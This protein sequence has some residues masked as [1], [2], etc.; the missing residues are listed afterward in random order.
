M[1]IVLPC[2]RVNN[3]RSDHDQSILN[4]K[5][6]SFIIDQ[7]STSSGFTASS[8]SGDLGDVSSGISVG[9]EDCDG[10]NGSIVN[11]DQCNYHDPAAVQ[12]SDL[13]LGYN[14]TGPVLSGVQMQVPS[15][16]IYGLLG[17]SGC[18]KTSLIKCIVGYFRPARGSVFIYGYPPGHLELQIPGPNIGYMPQECIL[19]GELTIGETLTYFARLFHMENKFIK[20]NIDHMISI[21]GLPEASRRISTLSGGQM[22]RVSFVAAVLHKP[23][24]II[25][26]EPTAGVDPIVT[27]AIWKYLQQISKDYKIAVVLTTHYIEEARK[28]GCVGLMREGRILEEDHPQRLMARYKS[29]TLEQAF[30]HICSRK[31]PVHRVDHRSH[32]QPT[33]SLTLT[34]TSSTSTT[35]PRINGKLA[36]TKP[37]LSG[38]SGTSSSGA[39]SSIGQASGQHKK[40]DS[41]YKPSPAQ[42]PIDLAQLFTV[43]LRLWFHVVF[44]IFWKNS[45]RNIRSPQF[46]AL[47]F[48]VPIL[49]VVLS[50][51]VLG[52]DPFD[53]RVAVIDEDHT[54][55]SRKFV[56]LIDPYF[57]NAVPYN[58]LDTALADIKSLQTWGVI[59]IKRNFSRGFLHRVDLNNNRYNTSLL[60]SSVIKLHGDLTNDLITIYVRR[61]LDRTFYTFIQNILE[62]RGL[63]PTLASLPIKLED[64]IYGAE[65]RGRHDNFK[66]FAI[67]GSMAVVCFSIGF[68]ITAI[69]ITLER[70]DKMLDRH[71]VIGITPLQ[72]L[73]AHLLNRQLANAIQITVILVTCIHFL[74]VLDVPSIVELITAFIVLLVVSITGM[75]LGMVFATITSKFETVAATSAAALFTVLISSGVL[76]PLEAMKPWLRNI[77]IYSPVTQGSRSLQYILLRGMD[78]WH[79][80]VY[81]GIINNF[82]WAI[83]F[84]FIGMRQFKF[85]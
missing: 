35:A 78:L 52:L 69:V 20:Q 65:S 5:Q 82:C 42:S 8:T 13:Y 60:S 9:S 28:A 33:S 43:D 19:Y 84:F 81:A 55:L 3:Y 14:N 1:S 68:T 15:A 21:L 16:S 22:R 74:G 27:E 30:L 50:C 59:H 32:Q 62:G 48:V 34:S 72:F 11:D 54:K 25:L 76:W 7:P 56:T 18:G 2:S 39:S 53:T 73:T 71:Y 85:A 67:P 40:I 44:T 83:L 45:I 61:S 46:M 80:P 51:I 23:K 4:F 10:S 79:R 49:P 17:P 6:S 26:D 37:N 36:V 24:L 63:R 29:V 70:N 77:A 64:P 75:C 47:Q 12:V 58:S 38:E 41:I 31:R 66:R 57:I